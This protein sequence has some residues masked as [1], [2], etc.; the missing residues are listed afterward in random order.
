MNTSV[1]NRGVSSLVAVRELTPDEIEQVH[2]GG[3]WRAASDGFGAGGMLGTVGGAAL[4][5]T[6]IG[7]TRWGFVGAAVGFAAGAGWGIGSAI[8]GGYCSASYGNGEAW[9]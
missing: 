9:R 5:G 2:G 1:E 8:Y 7:A 6:A 4:T 3:F